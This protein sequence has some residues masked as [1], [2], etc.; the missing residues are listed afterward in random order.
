MTDTPRSGRLTGKDRTGLARQLRSGYEKG[1][2][3]R[4]LAASSGRSYGFVHR[5]LV[6]SGASLRARGG[7]TRGA[8]ARRT[9]V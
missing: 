3:I 1:A 2:S 8:R 7:P 6:E 4:D 5:L 9:P